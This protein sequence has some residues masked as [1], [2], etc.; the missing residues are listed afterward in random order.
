MQN[1]V[2]HIK[3]KVCGMRDPENIQHL[4]SLMPDYIGFIFYEKSKRYIGEIIEQR[5]HSIIPSSIKKVGV[6]VNMSLPDIKNCIILNKLDLVQ[7]HGNESPE[8]CKSLFN[9]GISVIKAF[10]IDA[11]FSMNV[12]QEYKPY[13]SYFL[14]D[15]KTENIGGS[16]I[17]FDWS[18]LKNYDNEKAFFLSGGIGQ[19]DAEEIKKLS[20]LNIHAIDINS[21]F[22]LEVGIKNIDSIKD[23]IKKII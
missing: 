5:I 22:E 7:L 13:C 21:K 3:I 19:N 10:S 23:F 15:T 17:K 2:K 18:I 6:F 1:L 14:F 11:S 16:G 20:W 9:D 4:V 8:Y 12:L